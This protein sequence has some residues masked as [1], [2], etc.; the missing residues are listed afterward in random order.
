MSPAVSDGVA[1]T[2]DETLICVGEDARR[3]RS[4]RNARAPISRLH[5]ELLSRI[6]QIQ[7]HSYQRYLW[8]AFSHVCRFWR[9]VSINSS[10]LWTRPDFTRP[11]LAREMIARSRGSRLDIRFPEMSEKRR[12]NFK[13][14]ASVLL[15]ALSL[16][17]RR[18]EVLELHLPFSLLS[19]IMQF[20]VGSMPVLRSFRLSITDRKQ[21]LLPPNTLGSQTPEHLVRFHLEGCHVPWAFGIRSTNLTSLFLDGSPDSR[22][23]EERFYAILR[24]TTQLEELSLGINALPRASVAGLPAPTITL[25]FLRHI[26]LL[27]CVFPFEVVNCSHVLDSMSFPT[28]AV[29]KVG[30]AQAIL[31]SFV[32]S[33]A[34][35]GPL[36]PIFNSLS[37]HLATPVPSSDAIKT[38]SLLNDRGRSID[39]KAYRVH[40]SA[41]ELEASSSV[42]DVF[43]QFSGWGSSGSGRLFTDAMRVV[44]CSAIS[45]LCIGYTPPGMDYIEFLSPLLYSTQLR[46]LVMHGSSCSARILGALLRSS[47]NANLAMPALRVM[48]FR[49]TES[50]VRLGVE[51]L[52]DLIQRYLDLRGS[53]GVRLPAVIF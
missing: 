28:C 35:S 26:S 3:L 8:L 20:L 37:R 45:T 22:P 31:T 11:D 27:S 16:G 30:V 5:V 21:L 19:D 39:L 32:I 34:T 12:F 10:V 33:S 9:T 42:P 53:R 36:S 15:E 46:N 13:L 7:P 52:G 24:Q 29:I 14:A 4:E 38:L 49:E 48:E 18:I 50:C 25:P 17:R 23:T 44:P 43:M 1:P 47:A 6:F 2:L 51:T 41:S 40:L